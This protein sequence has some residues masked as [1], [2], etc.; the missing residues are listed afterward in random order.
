MTTGALPTSES[1]D[2]SRRVDD[3]LPFTP[4]T[5]AW[6]GRTAFVFLAYVP[7]LFMD[8]GK[9]EADTK[10][11]LYLDPGRLLAGAGSMWD[12]HIG[13]GTVSHQTIGYLFPVGPFY[14]LLETVLRMPAWVAQRLW[15]GTLLC[16]AGLG[17]AYLLR[18]LKIRGPGV[19]V[20]MLAYAF[21]P[22]AIEFSSRFSVLLGPWSALPWLTAFTILALR[23]R[24]WK[25][26]ALFALTIQLVSS[27]NATALIFALVGPALW[28]PYAVFALKEVKFRQALGVAGRTSL[29]TILTSLWWIVGLSIQ[30]QYGLDVLRFTES[31]ATV[32]ATAYPYEVLR[33]LGY[34]F[35]YGRD[36]A[37][38][39][40]AGMVD[41]T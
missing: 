16:A 36:R 3:L 2:E 9:V 18:T 29:L 39:W 12:P 4:R 27:I 26:P 32:S 24:G 7:L 11:Y 34:W 35:F 13:M 1:A 38:F 20:A 5:R 15:L 40:N 8:P 28:Y 23:H 25:Y 21:T 6:L 10:S 22:Y 37:S 41:F 14:W 30:G 31:L 17:I 19:P 33:G